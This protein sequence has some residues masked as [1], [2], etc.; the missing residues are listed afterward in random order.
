M[1]LIDRALFALGFSRIRPAL[2]RGFEGAK[3]NRL[4]TDFLGNSQSIN[5]DLEGALATLRGRARWL[6]QN[7]EYARRY[8]SL[9]A[10]NIVGDSGPTLQMRA[11]DSAGNM[12]VFLNDMV[13]LH[14]W[15]WSQSCDITT[16]GDLVSRLQVIIKAVAR[17]GESVVVLVR[18]ASLPYGFGI[19]VLDADRID[20][21]YNASIGD[22]L[23]RQ[24]VELDPRMRPVAL[25][26]WSSHPGDNVGVNGRRRKRV[27]LSQ[28][29]HAFRRERA[30]QVR[31][32]SWFHAILLRAKMQAG[33]EDSALVAARVGAS[34]MGAI[35]LP[36][37]AAANSGLSAVADGQDQATG[38]LQINTEP[39][40]IIDLTGIP[41]AKLASWNP[42]YPHQNY[43]PFIRQCLRSLA[44]GLDVAVHNLSGDMTQVN[45]SSA[46]IAEMS[47]R[48]MWRAT[49]AWFIHAVVLPI[50]NAWLDSAV[51]GEH[52]TFPNGSP[53]P[54]SR[55]SK[56][57]D[58]ASF[59]PRRWEWVDPLK[60]ASASRELIALGLASRTEIAAGKGRDFMEIVSDLKKEAEMLR[61]AGITSTLAASEGVPNEDLSTIQQD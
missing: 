19:Q 4:T 7:N 32:Y 61:D 10:T 58:A 49:Q 51:L 59:Q 37:G 53:F 28:V 21:S 48:D 52:L 30:E 25:W 29:I 8:L 36:D 23:I 31:G 12:D 35:E 17:D 44:M 55:I 15:R 54:A 18:D 56:I 9:V 39:G 3:V 50:F 13:E 26:L 2:R 16:A 41:G 40:E 22:N 14:W 33:F 34:K 11:T 45:Y 1:K 5:S 46:R 42:D 60:D 27:P 24:G 47:E 57:R 38:A 20:E 43:E 6:A